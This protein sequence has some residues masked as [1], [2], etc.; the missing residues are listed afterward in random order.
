MRV[1]GVANT[2]S[3][4]SRRGSSM[5]SRGYTPFAALILSM[6]SAET[7][8]SSEEDSTFATHSSDVAG[9]YWSLPKRLA[10]SLPIQKSVRASNNG[11]MILF[12]STMLL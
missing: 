7:Y 6:V 8:G 9:R 1:E 11:S 12:C 10:I 4:N 3:M 5:P 2:R